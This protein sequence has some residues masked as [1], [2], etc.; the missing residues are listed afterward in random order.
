VVELFSDGAL[1]NT[2]EDPGNTLSL[3]CF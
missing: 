2:D 3:F 1:Q